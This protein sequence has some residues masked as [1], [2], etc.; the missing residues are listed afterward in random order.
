MTINAKE[1]S[2]SWEANGVS[3]SQEAPYHFHKDL[4][5]ARS[6]QSMPP[7]PTSSRPVLIFIPPASV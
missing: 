3:F 2:P 4:S 1:Q 7:N 6:F 5:W